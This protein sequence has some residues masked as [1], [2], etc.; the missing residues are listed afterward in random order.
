MTK[1]AKT[2][3]TNPLFIIARLEERGLLNVTYLSSWPSQYTPRGTCQC[4]ALW[5]PDYN[6]S[7]LITMVAVS[8][9]SIARPHC[10]LWRYQ[11][12]VMYT[13]R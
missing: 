9:Y 11:S 8:P 7:K 5:D 2:P 3:T 1:V 10:Q 4:N 6:S 13:S 12:L